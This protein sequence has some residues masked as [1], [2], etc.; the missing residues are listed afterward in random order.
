MRGSWPVFCCCKAPD[1]SDQARSNYGFS[2]RLSLLVVYLPTVKALLHSLYLRSTDDGR[3]MRY[4]A[5]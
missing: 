1:R 3:G 5:L 2:L 4:A